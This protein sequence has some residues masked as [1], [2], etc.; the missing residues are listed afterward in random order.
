MSS[1]RGKHNQTWRLSSR[2][3]LK[4]VKRPFVNP[5]NSPAR[6]KTTGARTPPTCPAVLGSRNRA[7]KTPAPS[8]PPCP[9]LPLRSGTF[10]L[11][12]SSRAA[13][14][15]R[16]RALPAP[17]P[18][19]RARSRVPRTDAGSHRYRGRG[20]PRSGSRRREAAPVT[21]LVLHKA[22]GGGGRAARRVTAAGPRGAGRGG[23]GAE[24]A[25]AAAGGGGRSGAQSP[26][27]PRAAAKGGLDRRA[28]RRPG[29]GPRPEAP[30]GAPAPYLGFLL[31]NRG[32]RPG[33]RSTETSYP[34]RRERGEG[35]RGP[36]RAA[37]SLGFPRAGR[38]SG[39]RP[40]P[41]GLRSCGLVPRTPA[42]PPAQA[43]A[44]T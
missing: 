41:P 2:R 42:V 25:V 29:S 32:I 7:T 13:P 11:P 31:P 38:V 39:A 14:P 36:S 40:S 33:R 10:T 3:A 6:R 20:G 26:A 28:A 34:P 30:R 15:R 43:L 9:P 4:R 21:R 16:S 19:P 17:R 8:R 37:Q 35:A 1:R 23:R 24:A 12:H 18:P 27:R 44:G 5:R 22:Q